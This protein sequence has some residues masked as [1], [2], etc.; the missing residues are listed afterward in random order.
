MKKKIVVLTGAGISAESGISTYRDAGGLWENFDYSQVATP[1]GWR[2]DQELVLRFYN[3]RRRQFLSCS[4]NPGHTA[5]V[6][7]E[8]AYDVQIITQ[9]IDDLHEQ[10]GSSQV[11]HL[12]GEIDKARSTLDP[13][14]V[15][16]L[17][18]KDLNP[19]DKCEK[20][21]QLRPHIVWFGEDVPMLPVAARMC[22]EADILII[23]GTSMVVY[24]ANTLV[25]YAPKEA[26]IWFIDPREPGQAFS[27]KVIHLVQKGSKA[28]PQLVE[29]L[30]AEAA[31]G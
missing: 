15:Y 22:T 19:G 28:V 25:E 12:H 2:K 14:L 29:Q 3:D 17:N 21:S 9:N 24:P 8:S 4:P 31:Q 11:L 20:G 18:R 16:E 27:R 5:L 6:A 1:E 13:S 30:L 23:I 7:L 26:K 10:A